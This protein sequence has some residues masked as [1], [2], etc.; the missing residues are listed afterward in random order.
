M[1]KV[2]LTGGIGSGKS[3]V[4]HLF[5]QLGVP[6]IDAD[7]IARE[8]LTTHPEL[9]SQIFAHFGPAAQ[10]EH[11]QLNRA[12]LRSIIFAQPEQRQWLEALLHPAILKAMAEQVSRLHTPYCLLVIPLLTEVS[13]SLALVD[14]ILVVDVPESTQSQRVQQRD[15]LS[16]SAID[17][18]L[19]SQ[20][21][22]NKRLTIADDI[23]DNDT[24][25]D[26]LAQRVQTLHESYLTMAKQT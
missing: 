20:S 14:R 2:G 8:V 17:Q 9:L 22:R 13:Q 15:K 23:I 4:A 25:L 24:D 19:Q 7:V 21:S 16:P 18:I 10:D 12:F 6:V 26:T 5:A 3:T 1:L 11:G